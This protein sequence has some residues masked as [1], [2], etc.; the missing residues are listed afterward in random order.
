MLTTN[1]EENET[2]WDKMV[3]Y[4]VFAYNSSQHAATKT[5]PFE[6]VQGRKARLP[7]EVAMGARPSEERS[8]IEYANEQLVQ[9]QEGFRAA[10]EAANQ[11]KR[12]QERRSL[13]GGEDALVIKEGVK[14]WLDIRQ[15]EP[16]ASK[17]L[18]KKYEGPYEVVKKHGDNY[19][20]IA[21]E[22]GE[23]VKVHVERLKPFKARNGAS[24]Q[25]QGDNV[26]HDVD[27]AAGEVEVEPNRDMLPNDLLGKRVRVWWS[28]EK[29]WF[30][31][32]VTKRKR[33]MHVVQYDDG[34]VKAER[35]LGHN[36]KVAPARKLLVRRG[37]AGTLF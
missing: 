20:V 32:S 37:S 16:G 15:S 27:D 29:K 9:M 24:A 3:P 19:V 35:L 21:K 13:K 4:V 6:L 25:L 30:D 12:A 33:R 10:R 36:A 14:V 17:K 7:I 22:D 5:S 1:M 18:A 23:Q 2:D 8:T 31:G 26:E 34:E 28:G 11:V